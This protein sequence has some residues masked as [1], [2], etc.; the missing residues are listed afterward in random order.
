MQ[1]KHD[2]RWNNSPRLS[3]RQLIH[4]L[5]PNASN[6]VGENAFIATV[7]GAEI[8]LSRHE[9]HQFK[10]LRRG[11]QYGRTAGDHKAIARHT[12]QEML[13]KELFPWRDNEVIICRLLSIQQHWRLYV[14]SAHRA[15]PSDIIGT[16]ETFY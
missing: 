1:E 5:I 12:Q 16:I 9:R 6:K 10:N 11:A 4:E 13:Y 7:S 8:I 14:R 15:M 3:W 2:K